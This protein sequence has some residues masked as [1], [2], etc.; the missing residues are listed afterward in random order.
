LAILALVSYS[1]A[2]FSTTFDP[3]KNVSR[4]GKIPVGPGEHAQSRR[5]K[6]H[7]WSMLRV[8]RPGSKTTATG[9]WQAN[10]AA[11]AFTNGAYAEPISA[12]REGAYL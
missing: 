10:R 2:P 8:L 4:I 7:R 1:L 6:P 5:G 3:T 9:A 12:G 11:I